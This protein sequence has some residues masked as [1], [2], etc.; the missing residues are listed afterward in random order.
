MADGPPERYPRTIRHTRQV[1]YSLTPEKKRRP[2]LPVS[3]L[4]YLLLG[5]FSIAIAIGTVLL[6]LPWAAEDGTWTS[7]ITALF[8]S[9]SAVCVTGLVPVDTATHWS[10]FGEAVILV[11]IQFGGLG[12]MTSATLLFLLLGWRVGVRERLL[13]SASLDL[14]RPGG[15]VRVTRGALIFT[16]TC[17][18]IG[19]VL[20]TFRFALDRPILESLWF[21]LFHSVS[22]FN[23]AGFDLFGNYSSLQGQRDAFTLT[24]IAALVA[25][26][27]IGYLVV[28]EVLVWRRQRLSLDS[29][30][31]LRTTFGLLLGGWLFFAMF[32][33][34][35]SLA[36]L[37][38]PDK[39]LQSGFQAVAPRTA[40]FASLP[41][42][43]MT[44]ETHIL[45]VFLMFIGGSTGSTAGGIKVATFAILVVAVISALRGKSHLEVAG[46][47][48]RRSEADKALAVAFLAAS[49]IFVATMVI[50]VIEEH[51]FLDLLFEVASAFGTTGLS[52][53]I[54][55]QLKDSTLLLL[56]VLMFVGRLGPLTL[57]LALM[58][59]SRIERLRLPEERVRIG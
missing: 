10:G 26:G 52:T 58:Q 23:N 6:M 49:T 54:T 29:T 59:R 9:T 33:W 18:A 36:A 3:S 28:Q 11:L 57:A 5:G 17:E 15:V 20:L 7:P 24:V 16:L 22:A 43:D 30:L 13:L 34:N 48:I 37:S 45:T 4:P 27:G 14:S 38:L 31:V 44:E 12:F 2:T 55:P 8:I 39:L 35:A 25:F 41:V 21:G 1:E 47:E 32:E 19:F 50:A 46:R 53:G 51:V 40:G 42:G 56:T